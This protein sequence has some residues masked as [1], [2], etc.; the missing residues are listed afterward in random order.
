[1]AGYKSGRRWQHGHFGHVRVQASRWTVKGREHGRYLLVLPITD[2]T[3]LGC[4]VRTRGSQQAR[5][6][7]HIDKTNWVKHFSATLSEVFHDFT[8]LWSEFQDIIQIRGTACSPPSRWGLSKMNPRPP[9]RRRLQRTP[10]I[11]SEIKPQ[12]VMQTNPPPPEGSMPKSFVWRQHPRPRRDV[13]SVNRGPSPSYSYKVFVTQA[14]LCISRASTAERTGAWSKVSAVV[15]CLLWFWVDV[16]AKWP[17]S[18]QPRSWGFQQAWFADCG[19]V[20]SFRS[21]T[22]L[23]SFSHSLLLP[24]CLAVSSRRRGTASSVTLNY[25]QD[26]LEQCDK[27]ET[28]KNPRFV[29]CHLW[30]ELFQRNGVGGL[31]LSEEGGGVAE[32]GNRF[33]R[34]GRKAC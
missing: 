6:N 7:S 20:W 16:T 21:E 8:Q 25:R 23:L 24:V 10:K 14:H 2:Q 27:L 1:M 30:C 11:V 4:C 13:R 9:A 33:L 19:H 5:Q 26:S 18:L 31:G 29:F 3:R 32:E 15:S 34:R 17:T 22:A 12:R 28:C